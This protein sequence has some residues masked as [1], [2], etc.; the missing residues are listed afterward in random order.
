MKNIY[1]LRF[2]PTSKIIG[3]KMD[4]WWFHENNFNVFFWDIG[5]FF[6]SKKQ[7]EEFYSISPGFRFIGPNHRIFFDKNEFINEV[8]K[9]DKESIIFYG[10]RHPFSTGKNDEWVFSLLFDRSSNI[11]P[12]QYD[13]LPLPNT[14]LNKL[15]LNYQFYRNR[16]LSRKTRIKSFI[17]CGKVGRL[18]SKKIFP[19]SPFI[20]VPTPLVNWDKLNKLYD[21]KYNIFVD[22][23]VHYMPDSKLHNVIFNTDP[24]GYYLRTSEFLSKVEDITGIK[25]IIAA[26]GKYY[27]EHNPY[28]GRDIVYGSTL[29]LIQHSSMVFGHGSSAN[30]QAIIDK[31]PLMIVDDKSFTNAARHMFIDYA[32]RVTLKDVFDIEK[33]NKNKIKQQSSID[34]DKYQISESNYFRENGVNDNFKK[35]ISEN[36]NKL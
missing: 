19:Y 17:G 28:E 31:K 18:Y 33:I 9:I 34:Y 14:I 3:K 1:F 16:Y 35:I 26:S 4:P 30:F 32:A 24:N 10:D 36:L 25:T 22:E 7:T 11:I 2:G 5:S 23:H 6:F 20:S 29:Q 13:N 12:F 27:Y 15:K 21:F 8:K